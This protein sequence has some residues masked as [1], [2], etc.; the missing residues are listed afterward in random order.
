M[1]GAYIHL[2][3]NK[4]SLVGSQDHKHPDLGLLTSNNC[5]LDLSLVLCKPAIS[6]S[7]PSRV[8]QKFLVKEVCGL[9][10]SILAMCS[11]TR[12]ILAVCGLTR[13]SPEVFA[14]TRSPQEWVLSANLS[15]H[16]WSNGTFKP[17][18][19][20]VGNGFGNKSKALG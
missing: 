11:P 13:S 3:V 9:T 7:S 17:W 14:L 6:Y 15:W 19:V 20:R 16:G 18:T 10:R 8:I 1:Q 12:S 4:N 2:Q 5:I